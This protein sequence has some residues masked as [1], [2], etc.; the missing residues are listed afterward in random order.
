M[1]PSFRDSNT[2]TR[3]LRPATI[4]NEPHALVWVIASEAT[5][6]AA[7]AAAAFIPRFSLSRYADLSLLK[8]A[9]Y[10][11]AVGPFLR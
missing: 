4:T 7:A 8:M 10:Q 1:P 3:T 5:A 6:A 11:H 9:C 2:Y